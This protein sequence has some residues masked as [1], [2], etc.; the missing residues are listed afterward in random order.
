MYKEESNVLNGTLFHDSWTYKVHQVEIEGAGLRTSFQSYR[1]NHERD[2]EY[3]PSLVDTYHRN[4]TNDAPKFVVGKDIFHFDTLGSSSIMTFWKN[5]HRWDNME[6]IV[7]TRERLM[8]LMAR[9]GFVKPWLIFQDH[10]IF[11]SF[12]RIKP[13]VNMKLD[14]LIGDC[15]R[16][17]FMVHL[18]EHCQPRSLSNKPYHDVLEVF[19]ANPVFEKAIK[20]HQGRAISVT[21]HDFPGVKEKDNNILSPVVL[22]V[23]YPLVNAIFF[24]HGKVMVCK[25]EY[26]TGTP[27]NG[28]KGDQY[29]DLKILVD[30]ASIF[31]DG[32]I[33]H[34]WDL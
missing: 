27:Y 32:A 4:P 28:V 14:Q 3:V 16:D 33:L 34:G 21:L 1:H 11:P 13:E 9:H 7:P 20:D 5:R 23:I 25:R 19:M 8:S 17:L 30:K 12:Y 6:M 24:K 22:R 15:I 31:S 2:G 26:E 10:R 29:Y 18:Y